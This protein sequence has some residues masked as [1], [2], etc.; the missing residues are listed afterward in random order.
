MN[1]Q[2]QLH[3]SYSTKYRTPPS[4]DTNNST[5]L[6]ETFVSSLRQLFAILDQTN[7]GHVSFDLFK[8]YFDSSSSTIDFSN[9]LEIEAK[10]NNNLIT[11]DLLIN[12][13]KRAISF[14]K[15]PSIL[16]PKA[17]RPLHRS[18]SVFVIPEK[19]KKRERQIP[20]A[21]RSANTLEMNAF[22]AS[23]PLYY[24]RSNRIDFPMVW[25]EKKSFGRILLNLLI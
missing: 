15:T 2:Q 7:S 23:N 12:V 24:N 11:F 5:S 22:N 21:Y 8:R 18:A 13:I 6:P 16:V 14:S 10:S 20:I 9:E 19:T 3:R 17:M 4:I 1:S 25:K